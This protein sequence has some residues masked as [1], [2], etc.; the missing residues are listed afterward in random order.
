MKSL[1]TLVLLLYS[2]IS[3]A[4]TT[5]EEESVKKLVVD[6]FDAFHEQDTIKLKS[7]AHQ[8]IVLQS[9]SVSSEKGTQ[10]TTDTFSKFLIGIATIPDTTKFEEVLHD[11]EISVYGKMANVSTP[12]SFY[13]N[14]EFSHCGVNSF[15]L[16]K[17][18]GEWKVIYLVDT[19]KKKACNKI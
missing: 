6:F 15:Q 19:R 16:M 12:Y 17:L 3:F 10:L 18:E 7:F 9:I 5:S 11:F 1:F 13:L 14:G 4:Q 2:T 8:D